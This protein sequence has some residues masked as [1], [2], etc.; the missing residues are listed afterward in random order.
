MSRDAWKYLRIEHAL[1]HASLDCEGEW[2]RMHWLARARVWVWNRL[3]WQWWQLRWAMR[4]VRKTES[5][6]KWE[7]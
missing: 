4:R 3:S 5:N 2:G 6:A 1:R 7:S